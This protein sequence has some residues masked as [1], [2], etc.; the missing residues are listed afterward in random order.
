[1]IYG[2]A[3]T[4]VSAAVGLATAGGAHL[5]TGTVAA[6]VLPAVV[7]TIVSAVSVALWPMVGT[8]ER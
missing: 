2:L 4:F 1:V 5:I 8:G 6:T 7:A 3:N